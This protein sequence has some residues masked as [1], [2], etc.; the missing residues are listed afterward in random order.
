[1]HLT[2]IPI[3]FATDDNYAPFLAVSITSLLKNASKDYFYDIHVL[4]SPMSDEN[5]SRIGALATD[6]SMISF[7]DMS[8]RMDA[9]AN[10]ISLRDY[11]SMATY[12]RIFIA[13]MFPEYDKALYI[14][15]DTV[16][17]DDISKLYN[18][19]L[20]SCLIGGMP[21][22]VMLMDVFSRY[23]SVVLGIPNTEYFNAGLI[24]MNLK[25]FRETKMEKRFIELL[26]KRKFP[27]AQDQ[28][29]LNLLCH[30]RVHYFPVEWNLDP[31]DIYK[32]KT[33]SIIHYKMH[34]RPWHYDGVL[35]GE[36]FWK[37]TEESG[38]H[39]EIVFHKNA[40][41]DADAKRD[42]DVMQGLCD[43]AA[44]EIASVENGSEPC[45]KVYVPPIK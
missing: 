25:E 39:N 35:F 36:H 8:E 17:L 34:R 2:R 45:A 31:V 29:Y 40:R 30:G 27:V 9:I 6:N 16:I 21:E 23:S 12:F 4:T 5:K 10:K 1:M 42:Q 22:N 43:L 44:R 13:D 28:D 41:T 7:D 11:Y 32:D 14:D 18:T 38:Y 33:P 26:S 24:L 19:E 3:F 37:Y 20:G 15:S